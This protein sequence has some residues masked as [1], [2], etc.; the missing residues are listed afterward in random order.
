[1][2]EEVKSFPLTDAPRP[3]EP[4][5]IPMPVKPKTMTDSKY[6]LVNSRFTVSSVTIQSQIQSHHL[7]HSRFNM[8]SGNL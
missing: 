5:K 6:H 1:M 4:V 2:S 8:L 3:K 7:V